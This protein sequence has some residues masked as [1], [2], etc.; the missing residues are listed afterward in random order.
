MHN[1]N[2]VPPPPPPKVRLGHGL[3]LEMSGC[4]TTAQL[5]PDEA[6]GLANHMILEARE[7]IYQAGKTSQRNPISCSGLVARSTPE[8]ATL[9]IWCHNTELIATL[10]PVQ[11]G[12]LAQA[13]T[14][15]A[16]TLQIAGAIRQFTTPTT[17]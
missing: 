12:A 9:S 11:S 13:L 7:A 1:R 2:A 16:G 10:S 15:T 5:S 17:P 14:S 8:G 4:S 6:L 3:R